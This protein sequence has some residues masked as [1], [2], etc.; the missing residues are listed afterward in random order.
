VFP[1]PPCRVA[2]LRERPKLSEYRSIE[3]RQQ[4]N[5]IDVLLVVNSDIAII[6]EDKTNTKDHS[7]QRRRYKKIVAAEFPADRIAA[8]YL[9]TGDQCDY[10]A[11]ERAGYGCFLRRD[12]LQLLE[13]G[14]ASGVTNDIFTDFHRHG[15]LAFCIEVP[16]EGQQE[17][18]RDQW[19]RILLAASRTSGLADYSSPGGGK[20]D[21]RG[22]SWLA[23]QV[24]V[25]GVIPAPL[26]RCHPLLHG[27]V[28][29]L[30]D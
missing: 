17:A 4:W 27:L 21:D 16:E 25:C 10:G 29:V 24:V 28:A 8:V 18:K 15:R 22:G 23:D 9:K 6:I 5:G 13:S 26:Q 3:V 20:E 11:A 2:G 1:C 19:N 12:F 14:E 30:A 7:D